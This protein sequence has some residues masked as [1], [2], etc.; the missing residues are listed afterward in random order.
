MIGHGSR[1]LFTGI[2]HS[3]LRSLMFDIIVLEISYA[4]HDLRHCCARRRLIAGRLRRERRDVYRP[5]P[6]VAT[7][8]VQ[9]T[10]AIQF[11]PS[12]VN[13]QVGGTVTFVF[14]A[15]DHNLYFDNAPAGAPANIATATSNASVTRVFPIAGRFA[16][17]CHIHPGMTGTIIVQ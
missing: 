12:V 1:E 7:A 4:R 3:F 9:A 10:P 2:A 17:N 13:L 5:T 14:G 6:S 15:V 8:T 16:Y 11:T